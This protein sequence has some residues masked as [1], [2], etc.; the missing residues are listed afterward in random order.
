MAAVPGSKGRRAT[1][2]TSG[3]QSSIGSSAKLSAT[4]DAEAGAHAP[5][6]SR[7][8]V[9]P[10]HANAAAALVP[11][12]MQ[13][14]VPHYL[15]RLMNT[16]NLRLLESLRPRRI[17]IQQFRVMQVLDA[18]GTAGIG[19]LAADAVIEQSVVSRIV[20]K[21]H[22]DGHVVRRKRPDDGRNVDVELTPKGQALYTSL[23]PFARAIVDEA[24]DGLTPLERELL[25]DLLRRMFEHVSRPYAPWVREQH[26]APAAPSA[27]SGR[28]RRSRPG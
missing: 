13:N 23:V 20:D 1:P 16:L 2:Q 21:L 22:R 24:L 12:K 7:A 6:T 28:G 11:P 18:R 5:R 19:A 15:S 8:D 4:T 27:V 9:A 25:Q 3:K 17:T 26:P 14:Y 10:A